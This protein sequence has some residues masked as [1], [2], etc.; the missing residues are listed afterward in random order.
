MKKELEQD[1]DC[2]SLTTYTVV[3]LIASGIVAALILYAA[4]LV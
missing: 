1:E 3:T 2:M 4:S